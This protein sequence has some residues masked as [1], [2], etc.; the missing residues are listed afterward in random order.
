VSFADPI[1]KATKH[2]DRKEEK[3]E[4]NARMTVDFVRMKDE[5]R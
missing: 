5:L 3:E 4:G 1:N 2:P